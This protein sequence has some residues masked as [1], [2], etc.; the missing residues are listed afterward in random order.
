MSII[1]HVNI[2]DE[3]IPDRRIE[4]SRINITCYNLLIV[5]KDK[6]I[7]ACS[8]R[9]HIYFEHALEEARKWEEVLGWPIIGTM[10]TVETVVTRRITRIDL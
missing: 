7:D 8:Q 2:K 9:T 5:N 1:K 10:E 6:S 4:I 3:N